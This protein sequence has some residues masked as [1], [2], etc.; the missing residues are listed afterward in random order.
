MVCLLPPLMRLCADL[1][2][3]I[4]SSELSNS[5][6]SD[7]SPRSKVV[8][9]LTL[10]LLV[11]PGAG[12]FV[13]G[14]IVEGIIQ[15]VMASASLIII[16]VASVAMVYWAIPIYESAGR[17]GGDFI[18]LLIESYYQSPPA[19]LS[20]TYGTW[21]VLAIFLFTFSW[22]YSLFSIIWWKKAQKERI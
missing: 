7:V 15:I 12:S 9:A 1:I 8:V 22:V 3:A 17:H 11:Y 16:L 2:F 21:F 20:I 10:S 5:C 4:M 14:R 18:T 13:L 19:F 6:N